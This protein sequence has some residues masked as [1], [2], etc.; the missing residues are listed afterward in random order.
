[1][2]HDPLFKEIASRI[3]RDEVRHV[4]FGTLVLKSVY[5]EGL[6]SSELSERE[7]FI[8]ESI[9]HLDKRLDQRAVFERMGWSEKTW[10]SWARTSPAQQ[11]LRQIMF[12]NIVPNLQSLGLLTPRVHAHLQ[13]LDLIRYK[14]TDSQTDDSKNTPKAL[15]GAIMKS[16]VRA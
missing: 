5:S 9:E 14:D 1:M 15:R 11:S 2:A 6:T 10:V 8:I 4:A 16:M 12:S 13:A 7:E 3:M